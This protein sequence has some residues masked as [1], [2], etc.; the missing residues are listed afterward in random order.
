MKNAELPTFELDQSVLLRLGTWACHV[1]KARPMRCQFVLMHTAGD[2][3]GSRIKAQVAAHDAD[4]VIAVTGEVIERG[5]N[6]SKNA[7][8]NQFEL[9]LFQGP[10][11]KLL[12][13]L[14][15]QSALFGCGDDRV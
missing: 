8:G 7:G 12:G 9:D 10:A 15:L 13:D 14:N 4:A 3:C 5:V 11:V 2:L 6:A 1:G